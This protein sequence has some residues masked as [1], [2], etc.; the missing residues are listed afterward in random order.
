MIHFCLKRNQS[1]SRGE[2]N[3]FFL[4][5]FQNL[6]KMITF[7]DDKINETVS[8]G[9]IHSIFFLPLREKK[10]DGFVRFPNGCGTCR[11]GEPGLPLFFLQC[12]LH[13]SGLESDLILFIY[14][15]KSPPVLDF[16]FFFFNYPFS[17]FLFF[18]FL[19][20][21]QIGFLLSVPRLP[22]MVEKENFEIEGLDFI[23]SAPRT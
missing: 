2:K 15:F 23:V 14:F 19:N 6:L 8:Y 10:D 16:F 18:F 9:L 11:A 1:V 21:L 17:F 13:P 4:V 22:G 20:V 12:P 3:P 7:S 5:I